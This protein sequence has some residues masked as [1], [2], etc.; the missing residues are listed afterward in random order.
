[1]KT[2][3]E[4]LAFLF[5]QLPMFQNQGEKAF[6][7]KLDKSLQLDDYFNHPHQNYKTIHV[8]GTNGKGSV[9]HLIASILQSAGYKVGL[10]TSPHFKDFRERIKINGKPCDEDFVIDFVSEHSAII[11]ELKPSFF[12]MTVAMAFEY[13]NRQNVDVAVI[14]VGLGGRLDSTNI[15]QPELSIITNISKDHTAMLGNTL[16]EIAGEKA[17]IIKA[18]TTVIIGE[19]QEEV[20]KVFKEKAEKEKAPIIFADK[21]NPLQNIQ[22]KDTELIFD[23]QDMK[24]LH[25]PLR[26]SYQVKNINTALTSLCHLHDNKAFEISETSI[27]EGLKNVVKQTQFLGRW[28]VI[29]TSPLTICESGHN[30]AGICLAMKELSELSYENL[31]IIL[32]VSNDKELTDILPLFP[33]HATYYFTQAN[34]QRAMNAEELKQNA[35]KYNLQ[36]QTYENVNTALKSA[37]K[38]ASEKDVIYIGGSIFVVAEVDS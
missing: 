22:K 23:W 19:Y 21:E 13:F 25:C 20:A 5:S 33:K 11:E 30:E 32:G 7:N 15:I 37:Y 35:E 10:Y 3:Q 14:E 18:E 12:E 6:N 9:S 38:K 27:R 16:T 1:M 24:N 26:T 4:T 31:H 34:V 2:Y 17:G 8:G 36:G 29:N 28:Q